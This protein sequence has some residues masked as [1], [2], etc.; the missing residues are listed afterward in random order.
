MYNDLTK[1]LN[2]MYDAYKS[3]VEEASSIWKSAYCCSQEEEYA[4]D[5]EDT[6]DL[7]YFKELLQDIKRR[8][9]ND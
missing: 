1:T 6:E 5:I 8:L 3:K 7:K 2:E 4:K 9:N